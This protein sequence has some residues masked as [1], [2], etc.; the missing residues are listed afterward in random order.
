MSDRTKDLGLLILS[1]DSQLPDF[2]LEILPFPVRIHTPGS[3]PEPDI[4]R[5]VDEIDIVIQDGFD[6]P[7]LLV[8]RP[9]LDAYLRGLPRR[10]PRLY[11]L[12]HDDPGLALLTRGQSR[13]TAHVRRPCSPQALEKAIVGLVRAS[14]RRQINRLGGRAPLKARFTWDSEG[15][16]KSAHSVKVLGVGQEDILVEWPK[17]LNLPVLG[18][19]LARL[20]LHTENAAPLFEGWGE[21]LD[22]SRNQT[23]DRRE[24]ELRLH[25]AGDNPS[26]TI[27]ALVLDDPPL[28]RRV[29]GEA[30]RKKTRARLIDESRGWMVEG[31]LSQAA[32][33]PAC[34]MMSTVEKN[35]PP[36]IGPLDLVRCQFVR[37]NA[38]LEFLSLVLA[39]EPSQGTITLRL[40]RKLER[41]RIR[42]TLRHHFE[43]DEGPR[44]TIRDPIRTD[45]VLTCPLVNLSPLGMAIRVPDDAFFLFR[46]L[47]LYNV[48]L[49]L[50][51]CTVL[52]LE[53]EIR[54]IGQRKDKPGERLCGLKLFPNAGQKA[55][56]VRILL[57]WRYPEIRRSGAEDTLEWW[58]LVETSGL[59]T[60]H[61][62]RY[63]IGTRR[64]II[65][66]QVRMGHAPS[67][68]VR[69]LVYR[70]G[71]TFHGTLTLQRIYSRTW[72]VHHLCARPHPR[73]FV[74]KSLL[75][76]VGEII[77]H[78]DEMDYVRLIWRP[79][80][81]WPSRVFGRLLTRLHEEP[82]SSL[83]FIRYLH[84][85]GPL[86]A[87]REDEK[88][89]RPRLLDEGDAHLIE[90]FFLDSG[91]LMTYHSEDFSSG[92]LNMASLSQT[93]ATLGLTRERCVLGV[94]EEG[95]LLGMAQLEESSPG[96]NL[97][98]L[99]SGFQI[100][101]NP[102]LPLT[103][104]ERSRLTRSLIRRAVESYRERGR[105]H[106]IALDP[107][108]LYR[109]YESMGF[110]HLKN[111]LSWTFDKR[112]TQIYNVYSHYVLGL[113]EDLEQRMAERRR[114]SHQDIAR[115]RGS[116]RIERHP[117][118][119]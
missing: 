31:H 8:Q 101:L 87:D 46:G 80:N 30:A 56:L 106:I 32:D 108:R 119:S 66:T 27:A 19:R 65:E 58:R 16:G 107:S 55:K 63:S 83:S 29:L 76:T 12:H 20:D 22:I 26:R 24:V 10:V 18:T 39:L 61:K 34:V 102:R 50:S 67:T 7:S 73:N 43:G 92:R 69:R 45:V 28:V 113:Y 37:D 44:V 49:E 77:A 42:T 6:L 11:L 88:R 40:P 118:D 13:L 57:T 91:D 71:D 96:L 48:E 117:R 90:G 84:L 3:K 111:Y 70:K 38:Q 1:E 4:R 36:G 15:S 54:F 72:L 95:R 97:S 98:G 85:E 109:D 115:I 51:N 74:P 75:L 99:L 60:K 68:L 104:S 89:F 5:I 52:K 62:L 33:D 9:E 2:L 79:D 17:E 105:Q 25:E 110:R 81:A 82:H 59:F 103:P 64:E 114:G 112:I 100:K 86:E 94:V 41:L 14:R 47:H 23:S 21:V 53:A 35:L 93:Y 78:S 116:T